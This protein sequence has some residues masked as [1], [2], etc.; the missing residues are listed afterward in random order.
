MGDIL[1]T[2]IC[3]ISFLYYPPK[4]KNARKPRAFYIA[5]SGFSLQKVYLNLK[6][7]VS[8]AVFRL[9]CMLAVGMA[10]LEAN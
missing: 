8:A 7:T 4:N 2:T 1:F 6:P 3:C 5:R 10:I 9:F